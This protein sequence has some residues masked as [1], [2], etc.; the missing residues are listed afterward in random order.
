MMLFFSVATITILFIWIY[1]YF[2]IRLDSHS[3]IH[4]EQTLKGNSAFFVNTK[5]ASE[6]NKFPQNTE[7]FLTKYLHLPKRSVYENESPLK[8]IDD[9]EYQYLTLM[10]KYAQ[11]AYC[12]DSSK[13][14]APKI[15]GSIFATNQSLT[16]LVRNGPGVIPIIAT[17][18]TPELT[19]DE[20]AKM[21]QKKLL[22]DSPISTRGYILADFYERYWNIANNV[23]TE[24]VQ[25]FLEDRK[26]A[27]HTFCFVGHGGGA[28]IATFAAVILKHSR[29]EKWVRLT[30][31][32]QPRIGD[33]A[34]AK[35]IERTLVRR[36]TNADDYVPLFFDYILVHYKGE[37]FISPRSICEC[38]GQAQVNSPKI[39]ACITSRLQE[40]PECN[41]RYQQPKSKLPSRDTNSHIGPY[42][43][44]LMDRNFCHFP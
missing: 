39:F 1:F 29:A 12:F 3:V 4:F 24:M 19:Y 17:F 30:T 27:K 13:L 44:Y 6:K 11:E 41:K 42:L 2:T 21:E 20:L 14:I 33:F 32:G 35:L 40:H 10:A 43:G 38:D 28:I 7:F 25:P 23:V 18:S 5:T 15:Y 22:V 26:Y 16:G 9:I 8:E 36:V 37:R 34:F 31:F